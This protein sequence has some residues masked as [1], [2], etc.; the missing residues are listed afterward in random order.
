MKERTTT[1][2]INMTWEDIIKGDAKSE[3][4]YDKEQAA[5]KDPKRKGKCPKCKQYPNLDEELQST[6]AGMLC[7]DCA[8]KYERGASMGRGGKRGQGPYLGL[9]EGERDSYRGQY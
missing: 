4:Q 6:G 2:V 8:E 7:E 1:M 3:R 5:K 9:T